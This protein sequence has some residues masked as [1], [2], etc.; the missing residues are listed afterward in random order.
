MGARMFRPAAYSGQINLNPS[1]SWLS[2]AN[3]AEASTYSIGE[4]RI[5]RNTMIQKSL[6]RA[7]KKEKKNHFKWA[8]GKVLQ[9]PTKHTQGNP[10]QGWI[11]DQTNYTLP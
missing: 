4:G 10:S 5:Q 2:S 6:V 8:L 11:S 7:E 3:S 9:T 1:E